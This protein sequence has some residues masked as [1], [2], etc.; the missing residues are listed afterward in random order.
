LGLLLGSLIGLALLL[1]L[2]LRIARSRQ[3]RRLAPL[4]QRAGGH[5]DHHVQRQHGIDRPRAVAPR[6]HDAQ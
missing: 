6:N 3:H 5:G 1:G 2:L 4:Q